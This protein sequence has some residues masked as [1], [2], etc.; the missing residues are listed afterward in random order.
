MGGLFSG[1][2]I[3]HILNPVSIVTDKVFG[4]DSLAGQ[5][6]S[7]VMDPG[8]TAVQGAY[9]GYTNNDGN[10]LDKLMATGEGAMLGDTFNPMLQKV[11]GWM[12]EDTLESPVWD[13][14]A[15][16]AGGAL[17][18]GWG[19][20]AGEGVL[21]E[22]RM[23]TYDNLTPEQE[24]ELRRKKY[25]K[26]AI[27]GALTYGGQYLSGLKAGS[28]A[29]DTSLMS[30]Y[31][32][33]QGAT[34]TEGGGTLSSGPGMLS[35]AGTGAGGET[36]SGFGAGSL[37]SFDVPANAGAGIET[38]SAS[39]ID[40]GETGLINTAPQ[41]GVQTK[42]SILSSMRSG[43]GPMGKYAAVLA[44]NSGL[45]AISSKQ[46]SD[47]IKE[48]Q[49]AAIVYP[50]A[51]AVNAQS[52]LYNSNLA[53]KYSDMERQLSENLAGRGMSGGYVG[54]EI[55][56]LRRAKMGEMADL[57]NEMIKYSNTPV[58]TLPVT[59]SPTWAGTTANT[60]NGVLGSLASA[61]A[62]KNLYQ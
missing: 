19:A 22:M 26:S 35:G 57:A 37:G 60:L 5:V 51:E 40:T 58:A 2:G 28:G 52:S 36:L 50:R 34:L 30:G 33:L 16:I 20:A 42:P 59:V 48:A 38:G 10:F 46:Q 14:V 39:G 18:G 21:N 31:E 32:P 4:E 25:A 8:S 17:G 55:A 62:Y 27:A 29:T 9:E 56:K 24:N 44:L 61:Y 1:G 3:G 41:S 15:S 53:S 12:G 11:G 49:E 6:A 13:A 7:T 54:S 43:L 45:N 23:G 47:A